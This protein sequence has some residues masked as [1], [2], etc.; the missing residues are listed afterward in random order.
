MRLFV[1]LVT[2]AMS[3]GLLSAQVK[4]ELARRAE[5]NIQLDGAPLSSKNLDKLD[6]MSAY[7]MEFYSALGLDERLDVRLMI[8]KSKEEGYE[9]MRSI[10]PDNKA[11]LIIYGSQTFKLDLVI[12]SIVILCVIAMGI[13]W[14][15][16][17]LEKKIAVKMG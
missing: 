4:P 3:V 1:F 16:N 6:R 8:F 13:Y 14:G 11:Y 5:L 12:L 17:V 7:M 10:Y 9:Y 2:C 15:L